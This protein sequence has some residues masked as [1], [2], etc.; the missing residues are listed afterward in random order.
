VFAEERHQEI[1]QRA[2][3]NGRVDVAS[4]AVELDVTPETVRRDLSTLERAGLVR[5]VHGGAIAIERLGFEPAVSARESL[6]TA[7]KTRI[8]KAALA[9][10]PDSG[11]I[12]LDAGTTTRQLADMV[13]TDVE[14]TVVVNSPLLATIL[15]RRSNLTVIMLGGR[16]RGRTMAAVGD[17]A[18]AE[19]ASIH[20]DVA[21]MATNGIS[22][23]RGLTTPDPT[24]AATKAAMIAAARR[25]VLL[26]DHTKIG[27]DYF[28]RFGDLEAVDTFI[29]DT[30][31]EAELVDE[32]SEAGPRVVLA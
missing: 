20:V 28:A 15:A 27:N 13:P 29:T 6:L 5:R 26:A 21:F 18:T 14:L 2:R 12:L 7:E 17:W 4:L 19:L 32:I 3:E 25:T 9:E 8:G 22:V 16:V 11:A 23:E 31:A 10:L 1:L 30:G 24:E